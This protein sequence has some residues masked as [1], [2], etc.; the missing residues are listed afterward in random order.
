MHRPTAFPV[1][2]VLGKPG[3]EQI[4]VD[5]ARPIRVGRLRIRVASATHLLVMKVLAAR[6][7]DL[8]DAATLLRLRPDGLDVDVAERLLDE[9][10]AAIGEDDAVVT[11]KK[12]KVA[13][14]R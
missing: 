12:L 1:D 4:F 6:P 3:L 7:K 8:E 14:R 11:L 13:S 10:A 5:G 2:V 9:I